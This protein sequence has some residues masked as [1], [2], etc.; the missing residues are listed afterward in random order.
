MA[1]STAVFMAILELLRREGCAGATVTWGG[2]LGWAESR[3]I[4]VAGLVD[5]VMDVPLVVTWIDRSD[6]MERVLPRVAEMVTV[7]ADHR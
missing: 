5:V 1:S 4:N 6:R 3:R 7:G 2:S